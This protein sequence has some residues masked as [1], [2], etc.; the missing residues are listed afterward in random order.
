MLPKFKLGIT[1]ESLTR[2]KGNGPVVASLT[3]EVGL[4]APLTVAKGKKFS[5]AGFACVL[6]LTS[7]MDFVDFRRVP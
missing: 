4:D 1:E 6:T 2:S 5:S 3:I 7:D